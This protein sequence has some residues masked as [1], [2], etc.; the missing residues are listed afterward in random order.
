MGLLLMLKAQ[1]LIYMNGTSNICLKANVITLDTQVGI[2][3]IQTLGKGYFFLFPKCENWG[4]CGT[5]KQAGQCLANDPFLS[6]RI[7]YCQG[8]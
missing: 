1:F 8:L 6:W 4:E 3:P 5:G 2:W 7:I